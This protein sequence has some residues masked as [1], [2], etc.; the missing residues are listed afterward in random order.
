MIRGIRWPGVKCNGTRILADR[1]V[2]VHLYENGLKPNYWIWTDHG[3]DMLHI[4]LNEGN[5][6]MD[7]STSAKYV[8]QHEQFMLMQDMVCDGFRQP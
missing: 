4:D 6:Y 8:A 5:S 3:E 1:V 2:K 7:A